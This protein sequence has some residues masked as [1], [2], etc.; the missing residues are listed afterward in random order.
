[1]P[2]WRPGRWPRARGP[3]TPYFEDAPSALR[4]A[5]DA[6]DAGEDAAP[7]TGPDRKTL[8]LPSTLEAVGDIA[9]LDDNGLWDLADIIAFVEAFNAGCP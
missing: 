1:M 9:D 3:G 8:L 5:V 4:Q 7:A 2:A 6:F